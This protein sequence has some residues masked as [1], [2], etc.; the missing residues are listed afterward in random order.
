M[1]VTFPHGGISINSAIPI[2]TTN[3][4]A[5]VTISKLCFFG[6]FLQN[7][8]IGPSRQR[9]ISGRLMGL[10]AVLRLIVPV[11]TWLY[12]EKDSIL[13]LL[14]VFGILR[15]KRPC[16]PPGTVGTAQGSESVPPTPPGPPIAKPPS[17]APQRPEE[18]I[19]PAPT[20]V[21]LPPLPPRLD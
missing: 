6:C 7:M 21:P 1:G 17:S 9:P 4:K 18:L 14:Q 3:F 5:P 10:K 11:F 15:S 16:V 2:N 20:I 13:E 12:G 8:R 19:C